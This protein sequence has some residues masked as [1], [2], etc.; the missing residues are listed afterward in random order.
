MYFGKQSSAEDPDEK[1]HKMVFYQGVNFSKTKTILR[2]KNALSSW[3]FF[4]WPL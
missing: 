1:W 2:D 3:N 4:Q